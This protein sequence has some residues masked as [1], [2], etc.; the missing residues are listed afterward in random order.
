MP[1]PSARQRTLSETLVFDGI[2]VHSG[3]LARLSI[4]PAPA[5]SGIRVAR[6][7]ENGRVVGPMRLSPALVSGTRL[8]TTLDLDGRAT[9]STIEHVLAALNGLGVDN[10][11]ISID[12][13]ECPIMDG[14]AILFSEAIVEAG[15]VIQPALRRYIQVLRPVVVQRGDA[16]ALFE[17]HHG[18]AFDIEIEFESAAIGRQRVA[19]EWSPRWF[20]E[21]IASARTFGFWADAVRLRQQGF[22][23]GS[24]L[25]NSVVIDG[26]LVLNPHGLRFPDEF[27]RH[28][29]LDAVGDLTV[30]GLPIYGK[31][32]SFRGGHALNSMA[33]A[34]LLASAGNYAVISADA[35]PVPLDAAEDVPESL[36]ETGYLRRVG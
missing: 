1:R 6:A 15:L 21:E 9:I 17:P 24:S 22:A 11:L 20:H 26:D 25:A 13:E 3:K 5:D 2:G 31:F 16:F 33:L 4:A 29:L 10:A 27:A 23:Q 8:C 12:A 19:G 30:A 36:S 14:S 28:K 18:R 35:L 7:C 32:R 34:E